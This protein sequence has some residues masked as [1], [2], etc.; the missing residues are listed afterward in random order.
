MPRLIGGRDTVSRDDLALPVTVR[1]S[2]VTLKVLVGEPH[3]FFF[4]AVGSCP[5]KLLFLS[6]A[7]SVVLNHGPQVAPTGHFLGFTL[8]C[9]G[10]V[11]QFKWLGNYYSNFT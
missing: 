10:A 4:P 6:S 5:C 1:D 7:S 9:T 3:R 2:P 8:G 11:N